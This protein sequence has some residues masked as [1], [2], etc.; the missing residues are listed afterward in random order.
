MAVC[1][2]HCMPLSRQMSQAAV[3]AR[4]ALLLVKDFAFLGATGQAQ[5]MHYWSACCVVGHGC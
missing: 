1:C 2:K 4:Q 3:L 5:T